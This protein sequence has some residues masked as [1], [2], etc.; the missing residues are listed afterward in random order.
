M[1][2]SM[3]LEKEEISEYS[4]YIFLQGKRLEKLSFTLMDLISLDKQKIEFNRIS[5]EEMFNDIEKTVEQMLREHNI[6]FKMSVEPAVI[7]GNEDLLKSLFM[8]I[9]DNGRKA[10]SG[11]GIIALKAI[12]TEKGYTVFIQDNGCGMEKSEI[13]KITEAFYMIDKS[14]A[15]KEGGAGIGMS[16]CKK[17]V[18]IHNAKWSVR[19]KPGKGTIISIVFQEGQN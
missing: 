2:R 10:I 8:N 13:K 14:R 17:I 4:N 5:T 9:I 3:D 18:S 6:R 19:S 15:R 16:L 1:M 7:V 12:K 11:Q